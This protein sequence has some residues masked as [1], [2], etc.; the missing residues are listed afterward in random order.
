MC[1]PKD[2]SDASEIDTSSDAINETSNGSGGVCCGG[3]C[4]ECRLRAT[5]YA[6]CAMLVGSGKTLTLLSSGGD[7]AEDEEVVVA[8]GF[9]L[10]HRAGFGFFELRVW[11]FAGLCV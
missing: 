11:L 1:L 7:V 9:S 10:R 3:A 4:D 6:F 8:D 5:R 2:A